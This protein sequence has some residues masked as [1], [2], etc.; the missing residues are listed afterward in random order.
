MCG[1]AGVLYA[2][3]NR[4]VSAELL[5]EMGNAIAHRGPDGE[6]TFRAGSVGL[7][8]RRLAIIDLEGGRQPL[9]N[10]DESMGAERDGR[11]KGSGLF[12]GRIKGSGLFD[13][14]IH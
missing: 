4:S 8:H 1:I 14:R 2:D 5:T 12:D 10:E 13:L 3:S 6:G 11:R 9:S 7:V